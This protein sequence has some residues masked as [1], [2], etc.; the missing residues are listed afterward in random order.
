M[1]PHSKS[2]LYSGNLEKAACAFSI[3]C[4]MRSLTD[5]IFHRRAAEYRFCIT[6]SCVAAREDHPP[7]SK[8][9]DGFRPATSANVCNICLAEYTP[10]MASISESLSPPAL[11]MPTENLE[12]ISGFIGSG[13]KLVTDA[14]SARAGRKPSTR[15]RQASL[16][17]TVFFLIVS[18]PSTLNLNLSAYA[19][20][21]TKTVLIDLV[22]LPFPCGRNLQCGPY[23]HRRSTS[24][25][26]LGAALRRSGL[27]TR[28]RGS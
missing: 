6:V 12:M 13:A 3:P 23:G 14:R 15:P 8:R 5:A 17:A 7:T 18:L 28:W 24:E 2:A 16:P 27:A 26:A 22:S 21:S 19:G 4:S 9:S 20:N 11:N 1:L 10:S 25:G